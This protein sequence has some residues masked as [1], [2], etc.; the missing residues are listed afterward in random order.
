MV[1]HSIDQIVLPFL[2]IS[3]FLV[4]IGQQ[5]HWHQRLP[6]GLWLPGS[7]HHRAPAWLEA[8]HYLGEIRPAPFAQ[9]PCRCEHKRSPR[10]GY[11]VCGL[12]YQLQENEAPRQVP[13][14]AQAHCN[15]SRALA[16]YSSGFAQEIC[17]YQKTYC[18]NQ[19]ARHGCGREDK[20]SLQ[21]LT[22]SLIQLPVLFSK[23]NGG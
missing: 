19:N 21:R 4:C 9:S 22:C 1:L 3:P 20:G 18:H 5:S 14:R 6:H 12:S 23:K 10:V 16:F 15:P 7:R 2:A 17:K 11:K 13:G 8:L